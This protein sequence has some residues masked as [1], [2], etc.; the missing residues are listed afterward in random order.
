MTTE[1]AIPTFD[2]PWDARDDTRITSVRAIVTAPE[3]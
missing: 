3:G 2:Q 1:S